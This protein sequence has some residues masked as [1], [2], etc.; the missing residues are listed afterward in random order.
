MGRYENA[1]H[2][3]DGLFSTVF[4]ARMPLGS[5]QAQR[6]MASQ[7]SAVALKV[8][9]PSMMEAPHDSERECRLLRRAK[10]PN[11]IPLF[12]E[13]KQAGGRLVLAF[14]F[15][16]YDLEQ[17]LREGKMSEA[18]KKSC[19]RDLLTG[20]DHIHGVGVVHRDIKP[21]NVLLRTPSGPAYV[22]DFGIAWCED[23]AFSEPAAKKILDVGTTSYRPPELLFGNSSYGSSLDLW[24]TGCVAAQVVSLGAETL[25]DSG[26]L[27]SELALIKSIFQSLGTPTLEVWPVSIS[28]TLSDAFAHCSI[29]SCNAA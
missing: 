23:D 21:S 29:G 28:T 1:H 18:Q 4:V 16:P 17:L 6:D 9:T 27:G 3:K 25:F 8:T 2:Y 7:A 13:F 20:L 22:A 10:S 26:D 12:E 14:P 24:A 11:V 5:S 15:M 19:L